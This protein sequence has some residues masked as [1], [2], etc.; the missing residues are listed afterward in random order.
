MGTYR[1]HCPVGDKILQG[2]VLGFTPTEHPLPFP[3]RGSGSM[4]EHT[5][6][7]RKRTFL[8][9]TVNKLKK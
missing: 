3:S 7:G 5:D 6:R 1:Q 8:V 4:S 2:L 9:K